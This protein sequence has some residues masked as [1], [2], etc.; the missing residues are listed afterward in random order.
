MGVKAEDVEAWHLQAVLAVN[1]PVG[2]A[3]VDAQ[4]LRLDADFAVGLLVGVGVGMQLEDVKTSHSEGVA[5][6]SGVGGAEDVVALLSEAASLVGLFERVDVETFHFRDAVRL[7]EDVEV[8]EDAVACS[9]N[10]EA[11]NSKG[12]AEHS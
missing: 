12:A 3:V 7:L 9:E 1:L 8:E 4:V 5:E 2:E 6:R 10:V 11:L